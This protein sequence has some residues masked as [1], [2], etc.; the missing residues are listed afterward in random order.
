MTSHIDPGKPAGELGGEP[1][2]MPGEAAAEA[3]LPN[4]RTPVG[5]ARAQETPVQQESVATLYN[6]NALSD[7]LT[8]AWEEYMVQG[9]AHNEEMFSKT[10]KAFMKPYNITVGMYVILFAIG[11]LFFVVAVVLG[12]RNPQSWVGVAFGGLSVGTFLLFF[13]RQPLQALEENLEFITWLGVAFNSYWTR[14][15]YMQD[16]ATIQADLKAATDDYSDTVERL[17]AG[18]AK[19]REKRPGG[20]LSP[21]QS[22]STQETKPERPAAQDQAQP[23]KPTQPAAPGSLPAPQAAQPPAQDTAGQAPKTA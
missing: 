22:A 12:L 13:V 1:F 19:L 15:M 16:P 5:A 9:F 4:P 8:A 3:K 17:I 10:L 18:H 11:V 6:P 2:V 14:L 23:G 20:D 21:A 7:K